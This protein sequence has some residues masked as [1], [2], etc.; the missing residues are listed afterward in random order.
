[1]SKPLLENDVVAATLLELDSA[2]EELRVAE[3]HLQT[4]ADEIACVQSILTRER[5]H[6]HELFYDAPAPYVITDRHGKVLEANRRAVEFF[7]VR[8]GHLEGKPLATFMA[9]DDRS[10]FRDLLSRSM[11][12]EVVSH[13]DVCLQPRGSARVRTTLS[14]TAVLAT[15]GSVR[16]LRWLIHDSVAQP[17]FRERD[18]ARIRALEAELGTRTRE[19]EGSRSLLE[20]CLLREQG[21]RARIDAEQLKHERVLLS[22]AHEIRNPLSSISAW[23]QALHGTPLDTATKRRA[24]SSM[25]RGVRGLIRLA[26]NLVDSVQTNESGA[27]LDLSISLQGMLQQVIEQSRTIAERRNL[28]LNVE[29]GED[30]MMLPADPVKL[31]QVFDNVLGNALKFTPPGGTVSVSLSREEQHATVV[32][33]D[34]G[35]GIPRERLPDVFDAFSASLEERSRDGLGLGLHLARRWVRMHH[36]AITIHSEGK[37]R[38]VTVAVR[39]RTGEYLLAPDRAARGEF[40]ASSPQKTH[41]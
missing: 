39:L 2:H 24:L 37:G 32:I 31:K 4:Q 3:E 23:L 15:D 11:R 5:S 9:P 10:A 27:R 19:L 17:D 7:N 36:G 12:D 33:S 1:M 28:Q 16:T 22:L 21:S 35:R 34:T 40:A 30:A 29:L 38:G 6:Y 26:D 41:E 13:V 18:Q 20:H 14:L 25:T 8:R